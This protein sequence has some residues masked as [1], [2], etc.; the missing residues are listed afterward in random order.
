VSKT[1]IDYLTVTFAAVPHEEV[2]RGLSLITTAKVTASDLPHG[3]NGFERAM[4][5]RVFSDRFSMMPLCRVFWGG[6]AQRGRMMI[7]MT[8]QCCA[9]IERWDALRLWLETLPEVRI[10]RCDVAC[11]V[12]EG[13]VDVDDC[14]SWYKAGEFITRGR[15]PKSSTAG[16]WIGG[17]RGR[18]FYVGDSKNGKLLRCYEKGKELG[19]FESPW[20]R[21][22]VQFGKRD[23]VIPFDILTDPDLYFVGAYPAMERV[24]QGAGERIKTI[25]KEAFISVGV[26]C[27]HLKRTYGKYLHVLQQGGVSDTDMVEAIRIRELPRRIQTAA[28][29][30]DVLTDTTKR[31]FNEWRAKW[32]Q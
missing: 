20:V 30:A 17:V 32:Q 2:L 5:V 13:T 23:R 26:M 12:Y 27:T 24:L 15:A 14:V 16:D 3:G 29:V 19:D 25:I 7:D 4:Q 1:A 31:S 28:V 10:T 21:F 8:G 18:T 11:D 22:E 6:E 9:S